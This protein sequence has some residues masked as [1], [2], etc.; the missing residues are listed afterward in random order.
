M[1]YIPE[2][3]NPHLFSTVHCIARTKLAPVDL[4][5]TNLPVQL[6]LSVVRCVVLNCRNKLYPCP[7]KL[8]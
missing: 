1:E 5:N 7:S 4:K 6:S 2:R 3:H 8:D